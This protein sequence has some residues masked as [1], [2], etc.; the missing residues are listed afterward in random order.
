MHTEPSNNLCRANRVRP[1]Y[2]VIR[3]GIHKSRNAIENSLS[4]SRGFSF[5]ALSHIIPKIQ[6][7]EKKEKKRR[8]LEGR[9]VSFDFDPEEGNFMVISTKL[10]TAHKP[11]CD[12]LVIYRDALFRA[13]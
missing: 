6:E 8:R 3:L 11:I 7:E 1:D 13:L 12:R 2:E 5:A 4:K 10:L 9:D